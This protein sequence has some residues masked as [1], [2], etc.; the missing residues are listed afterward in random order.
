MLS[1]T[2]SLLI[3]V[4]ESQN[5]LIISDC[6]A[7]EHFR[8]ATLTASDIPHISASSIS[9][10]LPRV[11]FCLRHPLS[12]PF[13]LQTTAAPIPPWSNFD[14]SH[15]SVKLA[16]SC[17]AIWMALLLSST[18]TFP[19]NTHNDMAEIGS[20]TSAGS[21]LNPTDTCWAR[22]WPR[23]LTRWVVAQVE[24]HSGWSPGWA[25][26]SPVRRVIGRISFVGIDSGRLR[27]RSAW[28]EM[29]H[30]HSGA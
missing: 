29:K 17:L 24:S 30:L 14:R 20:V 27:I 5:M 23:V 10:F 11:T 7:L 16:S 6:C 1:K 4:W 13:S 25:F 26:Q 15:H 18:R 12:C 22:C 3:A 9:L 2:L 19:G 28:L 21:I 8:S